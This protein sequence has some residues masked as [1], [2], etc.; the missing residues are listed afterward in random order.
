[1]S[2]RYYY[3]AELK[4]SVSI[5]STHSNEFSQVC[6]DYIPGSAVS[7]ALACIL[8]KNGKIDEKILDR[9]FQN[10]EAV[11]SNCLPLDDKNGLHAV[12]PA[13]SCLHYEKGEKEDKADYINL[14]KTVPGKRQLKQVRSGYLDCHGHKYSVVRH[15]ST[16]TA[17]DPKTQAASE[18]QL[19]TLNFIESGSKFWGYVDMPEGTI[20]KSDME[21]FLNSTVR[22]GKCRSSEFG[23]VKLSLIP[24]ND[25]ETIEK[26]LT[27]SVEERTDQTLYLWC[28]SDVEFI[29]LNTAQGTFVPQGS[30][31]WLGTEYVI[32]Y[33]PSKSFIRTGR[34]RYF[35]R[36]RNGYDSEKCLIKRG[37]IICFDLKTPVPSEQLEKIARDGVGLSRHLGLGRVMVNP[38]WLDSEKIKDKLFDD[39]TLNTGDIHICDTCDY[40]GEYGYLIHYL[41]KHKESSNNRQKSDAEAGKLLLKILELYSSA[42]KSHN[43]LDVDQYG[44]K[45]EDSNSLGPTNSQW[46]VL[47]DI[48][49]EGEKVHQ[50]IIEKLKDERQRDSSRFTW[51]VHFAIKYDS[52]P[53][54]FNV[55]TSFADE[56]IKLIKDCDKY[57]LESLFDVLRRYDLSKV[58][59]IRKHADEMMDSYGK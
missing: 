29:D 12:F 58:D 53:D 42:R 13:P 59:T 33:N 27:G 31:L 47:L 44:R 16:K 20:S 46:G 39:L 14:V 32:T 11:F 43:A 30:N 36:K 6:L 49:V 3:I 4:D 15:S 56:F 55:N 50:K 5:S 24:P 37:S 23:R 40:S 17:I 7:G 51:D 26:F 48:V 38:S 9:V 35:N 2:D 34:I 41:S 22:I 18:S 21:M 25:T 28:L 57:T 45:I 52:D 1:M 19:F 10:N 54:K 8:Y